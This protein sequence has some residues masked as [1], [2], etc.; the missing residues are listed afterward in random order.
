MN[1]DLGNFHTWTLH[2]EIFEELNYVVEDVLLFCTKKKKSKIII[3]EM[4][5]KNL[6]NLL[7]F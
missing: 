3:R 1:L 4:A 6:R 5:V 7:Y 2:P